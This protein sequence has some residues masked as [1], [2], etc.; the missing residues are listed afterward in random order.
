MFNSY[1]RIEEKSG[2][3]HF[4]NLKKRTV[5]KIKNNSLIDLIIKNLY[6]PMYTE[7]LYEIIIMDI[8]IEYDQFDKIIKDLMKYDILQYD[9]NNKISP[10][11][12]LFS[13]Q[14]EFWESFFNINDGENF[15]RNLTNKH[16][17]IIGCG[18]LGSWISVYLA[19]LGFKHLTIIDSDKVELSNLTRQ[20]LFDTTDI[21]HSKVK[22]MKKKLKKINPSLNIDILETLLTEECD[23][24]KEI[25]SKHRI[26]MI[27][28]CADEPSVVEVSKWINNFCYPKKIPFLVGGGYAGHS[29]KIGT[30][31]D[32]ETTPSWLDYI[33]STKKLEDS[34]DIKILR[35]AEY[36]Y[37]G[38]INL[39][40]SLAAIIQTMDIIKFFS[41]MKKPIMES[42]TAEL[43]I[44]SF[45]M[46]YVFFEKGLGDGNEENI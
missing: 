45:E 39:T 31:I 4:S 26:D 23:S 7:K 34:Q 17:V 12:E 44:D 2:V 35:E 41:G 3:I 9:I 8:E 6:S 30:I 10:E 25:H 5:T 1:C 16:L 29:S 32:P 21:G 24:L 37:K 20:V 13:R 28:N 36:K 22:S 42:K 27:I 19:Q 40:A 15:Q 14:I 38:V 43:D 11:M 46:D 33:C 18:G